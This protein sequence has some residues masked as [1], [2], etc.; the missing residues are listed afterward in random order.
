MAAISRVHGDS[1]SH[2][3]LQSQPMSESSIGNT[4]SR[5]ESG[6]HFW[7]LRDISF[8]VGRGR[9]VGV[10]GRNGAGKS[11][12]LRL[13]ALLL[14]P[15]SG[16]LLLH[17]VDPRRAG[18]IDL[19]RRIGLLSHQTFLYGHLTGLENLVFYAGLYGLADPSRAARAALGGTGLESRALDLVR[20]YSRG[21]QQRLAI[22]RAFLNEPDLVLLDE[23]FTGLD[24]EAAE[25]LEDRLR[26]A[27]ASGATCLIATHDLGAVLPIADRVLVLVAGRL[28]AD[29]PAPG[30]EAATLADLV[31]AARGGR[32]VA[33]RAS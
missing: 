26:M 33:G 1:I 32:S 20:T 18:R 30:L 2:F 25:R 16:R 17:G 31:R 15:S 8:R 23:P 5:R 29:R 19:A 6:Q 14:R 3:T 28:V 11:T 4:P 13:C 7:G 21:M 9:T 24:R 12:L 22:A 27:R 10:V